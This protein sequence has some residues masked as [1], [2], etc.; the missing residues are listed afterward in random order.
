MQTTG[1]PGQGLS[2]SRA[3]PPAGRHELG[4]SN[5]ILKRLLPL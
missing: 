5:G 4:A 3:S 2:W 1:G